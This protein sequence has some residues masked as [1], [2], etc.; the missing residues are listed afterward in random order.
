MNVNVKKTCR[1]CK[2][3]IAPNQAGC[4]CEK[5]DGFHAGLEPCGNYRMSS[6]YK[7]LRQ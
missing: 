2:Y 7:E 6:I 5:Q 3:A 4:I 1:T